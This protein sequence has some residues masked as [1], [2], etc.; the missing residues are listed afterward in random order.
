MQIQENIPL[1]PFTTFRIG[2]NAR[3]Y[4]APQTT[5]DIRTA[6]SWA[7]EHDTHWFVLGG[8]SNVLVADGG[9]DGL[10]I[11]TRELN[12]AVW[13]GASLRCGAGCAVASLAC[14]A[15]E[16]GLSGLEFA[17]GLPGS[18]GGASAMN[19]RAYGGELADV[20]IEAEIVTPDGEIAH[21]AH[22]D[23]Q[24]DYKHSALLASGAIAGAVTLTL[25]LAKD[26]GE[27]ARILA[28]T[29]ENRD[30]RVGMGQFLWPS[31]G[32]VFKNNYD[33]G[34]PSGRLID[35]A[36]LKGLRAGGAMVF[37]GHANF[38][39]NRENARAEDVRALIGQIKT[40]ISEKH[41]IMLEEEITYLGF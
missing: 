14:E 23:M 10:V 4:C 22:T 1:A 29:E 19:A 27:Q 18:V 9:F 36:G 2:G 8:G 17:G 6:L 32:C 38:I 7:L 24:Y 30:K 16:R 37:E 13:E 33:I 40:V 35:E 28:Q 5:E 11:H 15:A 3:R 12:R 41:G 31:A 25:S 26:G 20:F 39:V 21:L 34:I